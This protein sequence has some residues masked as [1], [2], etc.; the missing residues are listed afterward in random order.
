MHTVDNGAPVQVLKDGT[1]KKMYF[2]YLQDAFTL[3]LLTGGRREDLV[4]LRWSDISTTI[5]GVQ[6][7]MISN[8][9]VM[10]QN[11][12]KGPQNEVAPKYFPITSDLRELLNELGYDDKKSTDDY[13]IYP[14]RNVISKTIMDRLSKSFTHYRK[15]AGLTK[16]ISLADLRKT[17]LSWVKAVMQNQTGILSSHSSE[18]ILDRHY[19]DP[20][21]LSVVEKAALEVKIFGS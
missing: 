6:F 20:K 11:A 4:T 18:D 15:E 16:S 12:A 17:Y 21:V 5:N 8:R 14:N 10:R 9:K 13:I 7:F 19:I 2:P 3:F 1:R